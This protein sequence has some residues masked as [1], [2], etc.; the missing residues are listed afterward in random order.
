MGVVLVLGQ[1]KCVLFFVLNLVNTTD[2]NRGTLTNQHVIKSRA[3]V[4]AVLN[5]IIQLYVDLY[6]LLISYICQNH[7]HF[8]VPCNGMEIG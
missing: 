8:K 4:F 2:R 1:D 7:F 5:P 3:R 6:A